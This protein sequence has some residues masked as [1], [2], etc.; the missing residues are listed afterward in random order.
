MVCMYAHACVVCVLYKCVCVCACAFVRVSVCVR[1][2]MY[3]RM[4]ICMYVSV[5]ASLYVYCN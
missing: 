3:I 4:S 1:A 2:C 5:S